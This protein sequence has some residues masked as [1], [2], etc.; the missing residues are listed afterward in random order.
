MKFFSNLLLHYRHLS[1]NLYLDYFRIVTCF[2]FCLL[3]F[4]FMY[5]PLILTIHVEHNN[6]LNKSLNNQIPRF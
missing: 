2:L 3:Y 5:Y 4:C 1:F 6:G